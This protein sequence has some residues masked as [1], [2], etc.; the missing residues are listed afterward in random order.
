MK[1]PT[2]LSIIKPGKLVLIRMSCVSPGPSREIYLMSRLSALI[3]LVVA[4]GIAAAV[5]WNGS[6][7]EGPKV[8]V[9]PMEIQTERMVRSEALNLSWSKTGFRNK[10]GQAIESK[11]FPGP[12]CDFYFADEFEFQGLVEEF[13]EYDE[14]LNEGTAGVRHWEVSPEVVTVSKDGKPGTLLFTDM[15]LYGS[16][17]ENVDYFKYA[18]VKVN[19]PVPQWV[20]PEDMHQWKVSMKFSAKAKMGNGRLANVKGFNE[21]IWELDPKDFDEPDP[22]EQTWRVISWKVKSLKIT[23]TDGW[24]FEEVLDELVPDLESLELA[25]QSIHE[26]VVRAWL[27]GIKDGEPYPKP[28]PSWQVAAGEI[29]PTVAVVDLDQ[30]GWDDFY[31]QERQGRNLFF[32]N[33]GDGTFKEIAK[34][35]GLD[36]D[37][38]TSSAVFADLD[39]D[40]DFD[41]FLGGSLRRCL[42]LENVNGKFVDQSNA[43][44]ANED[45]PF[46]VSAVNVVDYNGDGLGDIYIST[47]AARY[48]QQALGSL[49]GLYKKKKGLK[50][51][52]A[53]KP[54]LKPEDWVHLDKRIHDAA[55]NSEMHT[56]RPGP[57]NV[58]LTNLGNGKFEIAKDALNLRIFYN[59]FQA[60]WSDFDNDGDPDMYVANDFAPNFMF[61]NEGG[62]E[63]TNTTEEMQVADIGFGMGVS[64]GD[65]DNDGLQDLYV[66][67]MFSKAARRVTSFFTVGRV[68]YDD[69]LLQGQGIDP[70]IE[71]LGRGNSLFHN[72]G[73]GNYWEKVSDVGKPLHSVETAGWS[74]GPQF[75][76]FNNDGW[77]DIYAPAGY[78]TAPQDKKRNVDL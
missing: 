20:D 14:I 13:P 56:K 46:H 69:E 78:Y 73:T 51:Q 19:L 12:L 65:Y 45:L 44:I 52:T 33:N 67:N 6:P 29:H 77:L 4:A 59:S 36:F 37:G 74:W 47:Y 62:G 7:D 66:A 28:Y 48:V 32:H 1:S 8:P 54:F 42:M 21:V 9:T 3:L 22:D 26:G 72:D 18:N 35:L 16:L 34:E 2:M 43:W 55:E 39:N 50:A 31:L 63:F 75:A 25:R 38:F 64:F 49:R 71:M 76:D 53:L 15:A 68:N 40:G 61:R 27:Q 5:F 58:M 24:L 10:L 11:K 60:T 57:P 17:L 41:A 70:V 23:E 30:D